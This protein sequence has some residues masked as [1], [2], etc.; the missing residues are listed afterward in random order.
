M[1]APL[2]KERL[3][4]RR[5][6]LGINKM[7]A[8]RRTKLTQSGYVR[9]ENG[10]RKP[11]IQIIEAMAFALN[12]SVD[13]L[14]GESDDPSADRILVTKK[15]NPILFEISEGFDSL[16]DSQKNRMLN[17]FHKMIQK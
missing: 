7:D 1:S 6:A 15:D 10:E 4:E 11:T 13:Y 17:Y 12:T 8:A 16:D 14:I 9:Y 5:E 2:I 3:I